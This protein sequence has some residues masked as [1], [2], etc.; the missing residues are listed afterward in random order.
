MLAPPAAA[1]PD[2]H[3]ESR[4]PVRRDCEARC[5]VPQHGHLPE[6]FVRDLPSPPPGLA[7]WHL[8]AGRYE[9]NCSLPGHLIVG[10]HARLTVTRSSAPGRAASQRR[11][12]TRAYGAPNHGADNVGHTVAISSKLPGIDS[13]GSSPWLAKTG[14]ITIDVIFQAPFALMYFSV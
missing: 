1:V 6:S 4:R 12:T 14:V 9:V 2:H 13:V 8:K 11:S 3:R 7:T 5:R 10:M